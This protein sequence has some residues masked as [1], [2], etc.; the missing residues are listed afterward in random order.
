MRVAIVGLGLIGT[1]IARSWARNGALADGF[2]LSSEHR[3]FVKGQGWAIVH[4]SLEDAV[5]SADIVVL[6]T[7]VPA[8]ASIVTELTPYLKPGAVLTDVGSMKVEAV[9]AVTSV[10][11]S[12]ITFVPAHPIAGLERH[13]PQN[14]KPEMFDGHWCVLTPLSEEGCDLAT[15]FWEGVGMKVARLTA[16]VHDEVLGFTSH[17]PHLLSFGM[18][19]AAAELEDEEGQPLMRF[20]AGSFRD[21][22][23]IARSDPSLW[24]DIL[25][26]NAH[27]LKMAYE[28]LKHQVEPVL[29]ALTA[30]DRETARELL[31][32]Q[33]GA[34]IE[35]LTGD[36]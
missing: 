32:K 4:E 9:H 34:F 1:S 25:L 13:G 22:T 31:T 24:A 23:R 7:P 11:P 19:G 21:F 17:L 33:N 18:A 16:K 8:Y 6:A 29:D 30:G 5:T 20:S 27:N 2:D 26:A 12:H 28:L 14:S 3:S 36:K 35:R 15:A 10:L